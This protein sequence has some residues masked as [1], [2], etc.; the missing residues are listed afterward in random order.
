MHAHI[1]IIIIINVNTP[2]SLLFYI[3]MCTHR[4]WL[5]GT[6]GKNTRKQTEN[7]HFVKSKKEKP[8]W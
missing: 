7:A 8:P 5:N 4:E 3:K 1:I 6:T 2:L